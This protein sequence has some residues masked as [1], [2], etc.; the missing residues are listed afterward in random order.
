MGVQVVPD[1]LINFLLPTVAPAAAGRTLLTEKQ[2]EINYISV[3]L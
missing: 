2:N 3:G 1:T